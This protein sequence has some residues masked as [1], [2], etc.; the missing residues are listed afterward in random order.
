MK[1][2][3]KYDPAQQPHDPSVNPSKEKPIKDPTQNPKDPCIKPSIND[4]ENKTERE[5]GDPIEL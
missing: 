1:N 4:P 2:D 3:L 5:T